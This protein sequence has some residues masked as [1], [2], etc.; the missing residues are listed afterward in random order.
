MPHID[1]ITMHRSNMNNNTIAV[2]VDLMPAGHVRLDVDIPPAL[3]DAIYHL[4]SSAADA[5]EAK[6]HAEIIAG[7]E[8]QRQRQ[9]STPALPNDH[10]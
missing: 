5:H 9:S 3:H 1:T 8:L 7:R 2:Y 4:A 10:D 6:M